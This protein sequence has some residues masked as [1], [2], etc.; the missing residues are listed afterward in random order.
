MQNIVQ[1]APLVVES[2][3]D[4]VGGLSGRKVGDHVLRFTAESLFFG[5]ALVVEAKHDASYSVT[6]A[7]AELDVA[8]P[9]RNTQVGLFMMVR[10]HAPVGFPAMARY[11]SDTL[12]TWD[13]DDESTDP[14]LHA[15]V[16]LGLAL[17]SRQQH[18]ADPGN[19]EALADIEHRVNQEL[20][21]H[22]T[23]RKLAER[24]RKD[25]EELGEELR[26]ERAKREDAELTLGGRPGGVRV[27]GGCRGPARAD[28]AAPRPAQARS[29]LLLMQLSKSALSSPG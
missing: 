12:V 9:N 2:V 20:R 25:A 10:T 13:A 5:S 21:R 26:P 29:G 4:V 17:A 1:G 8:R 22:E 28:G 23:M 24:I 3:G 11:G 15:A 18:P 27:A 16:I 7:L 19:V 6:K 14:Y